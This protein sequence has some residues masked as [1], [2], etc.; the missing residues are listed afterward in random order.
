MQGV[1][2]MVSRYINLFPHYKQRLMELGF[3]NITITNLER[4]G[5]YSMISEL[6][7]K[8]LFIDSA[9]KKGDTPFWITDLRKRFRKQN[10]IVISFAEYPDD[11]AMYC[12]ENGANSY[13]NKM[14]GMDEYKKGMR[15]ILKGNEYISPGIIERQRIRDCVIPTGHITGGQLRLTK[16]TANGFTNAEI[17]KTFEISD[18]SV[19]ARKSELYTAMNVRNAVELTVKALR[20]GFANLDE[21]VFYG[22]DYQLKPFPKKTKREGRKTYAY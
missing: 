1:A 13:V 6:S 11:L 3:M 12:I 14:D 20:M 5:L 9:Y 18:S 7:P 4:D 19:E 16:I 22:D 15:E 10:I 21:I 17:A 2:L 8:Y